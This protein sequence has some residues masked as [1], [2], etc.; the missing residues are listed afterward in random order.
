MRPKH[1]RCALVGYA[2]QACVGGQGDPCLGG[3][4]ARTDFGR[5]V[6]T[7]TPFREA[8][9]GNAVREAVYPGRD[10]IMTIL[11]ER[12]ALQKKKENAVFGFLSKAMRGSRA[13]ISFSWIKRPRTGDGVDSV[14]EAEDTSPLDI[15]EPG[16]KLTTGDDRD[17]ES[18][19]MLP[20]SQDNSKVCKH[21]LLV[22]VGSDSI[23]VYGSHSVQE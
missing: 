2:V 23:I 20:I 12:I 10:G 13:A 5:R 6:W 18:R 9:G 22:W 15:A 7:K 8:A 17:T 1:R 19:T 11:Y 3:L 21:T 4:S 14:P 16:L